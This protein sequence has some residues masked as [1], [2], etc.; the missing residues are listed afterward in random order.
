[1]ITTDQYMYLKNHPSFN[2]LSVE[3]FD[4]LAKEIRF[5]RIPK[6]QVIFYAEDK[7]DYLFVIGKGM[8][9]FSSMMRRTLTA[10]WITF[11]RAVHFLLEICFR[12][13]PTIIR[14]LPSRTWS[15]LLFLWLFMK[16]IPCAIRGNWSISIENCPIS[17]V[18]RSCVCAM[19]WCQRPVVEWFRS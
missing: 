4:Q 3:H 5:R 11:G 13:R 12:T 2:Q 16:S 8:L 1:M 7:R 9:G 18:F 6:G 19:P 17:C 15:S 10:T 14:P